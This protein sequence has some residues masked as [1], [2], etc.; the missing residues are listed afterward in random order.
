MTESMRELGMVKLVQIQP[1]GLIVKTDGGEIYDPSRRVEVDRLLITQLGIE[2]LINGDR[3]LDIHHINH[4]DKAYDNKDLVSIGFTSHY[5]AIREQ[6]GEH[7]MDGTAG[8]N[9]INMN[10]KS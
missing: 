3:V 2:T 9:I 7:M 10:T 1:S 4:P 8:E 6:F 5:E